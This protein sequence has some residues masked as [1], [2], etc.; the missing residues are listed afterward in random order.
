MRVGLR[1]LKADGTPFVGMAAIYGHLSEDRLEEG[2]PHPE[3]P[4][5]A[6]G[7]V[8]CVGPEHPMGAGY[9]ELDYVSSGWFLLHPMGHAPAQPFPVPNR[10]GQTFVVVRAGTP[11][12]G[13]VLEWDGGAPPDLPPLSSSGL[14]PRPAVAPPM[15]FRRTEPPT[16]LDGGS[17]I[18]LAGV[19]TFV[20]FA[21]LNAMND[22]RI[23]TEGLEN[24]M[25]AVH[26]VGGNVFRVLRNLGIKNRREDFLHSSHHD[27]NVDCRFP[28]LAEGRARG[29]YLL[30][31]FTDEPGRNDPARR[32]PGYSR[33]DNSLDGE[34]VLTVSLMRKM[35]D[36]E[37]GAYRIG[38]AWELYGQAHLLEIA[39]EAVP[40]WLSAETNRRIYE[41]LGKNGWAN[42]FTSNT[43][44]VDGSHLYLDGTPI[45][46]HAHPYVPRGP[47]GVINYCKEISRKAKGKPVVFDFDGTRLWQ[48]TSEEFPGLSQAL[49]IVR[50]CAANG[51][52][53]IA[54]LTEPYMPWDPEV[55]VELPAPFPESNDR[56]IT[57]LEAMRRFTAAAGIKP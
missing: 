31:C 55:V 8:G 30:E 23:T 36:R 29:V 14:K 18:E 21:F 9:A 2:G 25:A 48:N 27:F 20:G 33:A 32:G 16:N 3:I 49:E 52:G 34:S 22:L 46:V 5:T 38:G 11:G 13:T 53:V 28:L 26:T 37:L 35:V 39:N 45:T 44:R 43:N 17:L 6:A 19:R 24:I 57:T 40:S 54:N 47:Q 42:R 15:G 4:G 1:V 56:R 51:I 50:A 7:W 12:N 10:A 41:E